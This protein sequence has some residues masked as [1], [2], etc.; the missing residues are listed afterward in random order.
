MAE[1]EEEMRSIIEGE[2][3][4]VFVG[5]TEHLLRPNAIADGSEG[6]NADGIIRV[7]PRPFYRVVLIC[8]RC[9]GRLSIIIFIARH[10]IHFI[11]LDF[12]ILVLD[13]GRRPCDVD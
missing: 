6:E 4:T 2:I 7:L 10:K 3:I 5:D 8:S 9:R 12:S 1:K 13:N 11:A